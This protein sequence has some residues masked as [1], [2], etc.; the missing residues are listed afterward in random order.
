VIELKDINT[1]TEEE[2][3]I[4][5]AKFMGLD[6]R[7]FK[8]DHM[9]KKT[10][11][12]LLYGKLEESKIDFPMG[13][14]PDYCNDLNLVYEVEEKLYKLLDDKRAVKYKEIKLLT[15]HEIKIKNRSR[16]LD[17]LVQGIQCLDGISYEITDI[18]HASALDRCKAILMTIKESEKE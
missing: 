4:E 11:A 7:L 17:N 16:Y 18:L 2:I 8:S 15:G 5:I 9:G 3:N 1:M 6:V 14:L 10:E 13:P 12:Y